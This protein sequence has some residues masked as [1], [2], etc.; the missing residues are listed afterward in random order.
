[1]TMKE[2]R[3]SPLALAVL[4]LLDEAP[5]HP[6]RMQQL[7]RQRHKEAVINVR[8]RSSLY[9]TIDRLQRAGLI[10]VQETEKADNFPE[11]TI[12]RLTPAGKETAREWLREMLAQPVAEYPEFPAA[13]SFMPMLSP[14]EAQ[15]LLAER[16]TRLEASIAD[17]D[18]KLAAVAPWLPRLFTLEVDYQRTVMQ[19][20]LAWLRA[21]LAELASGA[22]HWDDA[23]LQAQTPPPEEVMRS[24]NRI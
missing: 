23:W 11:R 17:L 13:L 18:H 15:T 20:E 8:L 10:A 3:R 6:Y 7:I 5:M 1:M 9:Q 21:V 2:T 24:L 22:L 16:A 19:A 4:A 14:D 12:Y